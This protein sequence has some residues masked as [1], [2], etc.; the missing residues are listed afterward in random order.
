MKKSNFLKISC[1]RC[2][3]KQITFSK[4]SIKIVKCIKCNNALSRAQGGKAKIRAPVCE[5]Y[6]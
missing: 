5:V 3:N 4:A 1:P 2:G 6:V